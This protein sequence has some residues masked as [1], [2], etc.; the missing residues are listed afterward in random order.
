M[1]KGRFS[2]RGVPRTG[3]WAGRRWVVGLLGALLFLP[4]PAVAQSAADK[5]TARELASDGIKRF[6]AGDTEAAL[7]RLQKAQAL[8]D[9]PIHLL[10]IARAQ[11]ELGQLVEAAET[12]RILQRTVLPSDAPQVF[13]DA[14]RSAAQELA[15]VEPR[16]ATLT[17]VVVPDEAS[18]VTVT[19]D[20]EPLNVAALGVGRPSNP[21]THEVVVSAQGFRQERRS[22]ELEEGGEDT[23]RFQLVPDEGGGPADSTPA[24]ESDATGDEADPGKAF[25]TGPMGFIVGLRFFAAV[26]MGQLESGTPMNDYFGPG[27][28]GRIDLGFRFLDHFGAKVYVNGGILSA[29]GERGALGQYAEL[30]PEGTP[31]DSTSTMG[32]L[33]L[34]LLATSDPRKL[35]AYGELGLSFVQAYA[36]NQEVRPP[37]GLG[38]PCENEAAYLGAAIHLGGGINIPIDELFTLVPTATLSVGQL[39]RRVADYGCTEL[40]PDSFPDR[41]E[42]DLAEE[43]NFQLQFGI[44]GDFHFGDDWFR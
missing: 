14:K 8:Y 7:E 34:S 29:R 2:R 39:R 11:A 10:Y 15:Q 21:G 41:E 23:L 35:G 32:E 20:G 12:Y 18:E 27:G 44:G 5:A 3:W 13:R 22:V 42:E 24:K 28:T 19:M 38:D 26:P 37:E 17:I 30:T 9:A 16:I 6:Q 43:L 40:V 31:V 25:E 33:G 4:A 36:W 1:G